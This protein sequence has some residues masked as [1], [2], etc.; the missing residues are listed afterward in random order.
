MNSIT[1]R[2]DECSFDERVRCYQLMQFEFAGV[3]FENFTRDFDEKQYVMI[4]TNDSE[5]IV[6]FSTLMEMD[7]NLEGKIMKVIFS[8]D[9]T[10]LHEHRDSF[11]FGFELS[12][13]F[14]RAIDLYPSHEVYYVLI[15]KGWRTYRVLPFYF[16]EFFPCYERPIGLD[17]KSLINAFGY[18]KYPDNYVEETGLLCFKGE[19]ERL[20]PE[21]LD[22]SLPPRNNPHVN[23]FFKNNPS[24]LEGT[25]LVCMAKVSH[26]NFTRVVS[27]LISISEKTKEIV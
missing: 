21:S 11:G 18:K 19:T 22:A 27:K 26:D 1:K 5:E 14:I 23:F 15:S 3:N 24:Y 16:K 12:K 9:T 13:F 7:I 10:V 25:E 2:I 17:E 8:G 4:L 20:R 6:G